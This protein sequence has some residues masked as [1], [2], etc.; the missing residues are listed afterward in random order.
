LTVLLSES[1]LMNGTLFAADEVIRLSP[2]DSPE[3]EL[4]R[5]VKVRS[6]PGQIAWQ[7]DEIC[8]FMRFG[9]NPF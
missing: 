5:A 4:A 8:A 1:F 9:I 3:S 2:D 7:R 6:T